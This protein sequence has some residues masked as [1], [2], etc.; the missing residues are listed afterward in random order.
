MPFINED[1]ISSVTTKQHKIKRLI[2]NTKKKKEK[3]DW[4]EPPGFVLILGVLSFNI[5]L[6]YLPISLMEKIFLLNSAIIIGAS[7]FWLKKK[8][9]WLNR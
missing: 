2:T 7:S 1:M 6:W 4:F 9:Q 8:I 3:L 5:S